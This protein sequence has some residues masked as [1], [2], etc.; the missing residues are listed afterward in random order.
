M[1]IYVIGDLHLSFSVDKPMDIFGIQWE[2]HA[3]KIKGNWISKVKQTDTV[4]L[5]GD[6]SWATYL[7]ETYEDFK[8]LNDLPGKKIL[9]KGNHDTC[10]W[11]AYKEKLNSENWLSSKDWYIHAINPLRVQYP[12]VLDTNNIDGGYYYIDFPLQKIRVININTS[13]T[14][15]LN[16]GR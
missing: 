15:Y 11:F 5:P 1:S 2:N 13:D 6:F 16:T 14:V 7:E 12:M 10:E 4:I 9:S 3:E 8:F